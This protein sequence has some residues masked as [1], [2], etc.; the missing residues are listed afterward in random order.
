MGV[1]EGPLMGG[2]GEKQDMVVGK[3]VEGNKMALHM[4]V[5]IEVHHT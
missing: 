5:D 4:V 3:G 1:G 2:G